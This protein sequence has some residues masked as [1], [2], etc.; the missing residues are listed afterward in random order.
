MVD[1]ESGEGVFMMCFSV[2]LLVQS[3]AS[4]AGPA[5]VKRHKSLEFGSALVG[6]PVFVGRYVSAVGPLVG[7]LSRHD[8]GLAHASGIER[9]RLGSRRS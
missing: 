6:R 8:H 7:E 9:P 1:G 2:S 3:V 5:K 4:D